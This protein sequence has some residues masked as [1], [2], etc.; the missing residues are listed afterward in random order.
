MTVLGN[1]KHERFVVL[2]AQGK[3]YGLAYS[4]AGYSVQNP[5]T[6]F[7]LGSRLAKKD[8]VRMRL[9][10]IAAQS[11]LTTTDVAALL[12]ERAYFDLRSVITWKTNRHGRTRPLVRD[13]D[14]LTEAQARQ[15]KSVKFDGRGGVHFQFHDQ[16][17]AQELLG[18]HLGMWQGES[19]DITPVVIEQ[20]QQLVFVD[21][22]RHE[23]VEEWQARVS[24]RF[25]AQCP[26][27]PE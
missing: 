16:L 10:E 20:K 17:P 26:K 25:A 6:A 3:S 1:P 11:G 15:I 7:K 22:P 5:A 8:D 27:A 18:K 9:Q 4:E 21:A 14:D 19:A 13:S 12:R 2:V 24:K 23:T